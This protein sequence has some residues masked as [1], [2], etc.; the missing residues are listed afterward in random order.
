MELRNVEWSRMVKNDFEAGWMDVMKIKYWEKM[1]T[2]LLIN[3]L[4]CSAECCKSS[5]SLGCE[6]SV[7]SGRFSSARWESPP[8]TLPSF[9]SHEHKLLHKLQARFF[10]PSLLNSVSVSLL[11]TGRSKKERK[12]KEK[13]TKENWNNQKKK[14]TCTEQLGW[15]SAHHMLFQSYF[16]AHHR[17]AALFKQRAQ[18]TVLT[19]SRFLL[20]A[21]V[22][23]LIMT[24]R[25]N[26]IRCNTENIGLTFTL[27]AHSSVAVPFWMN[28]CVKVWSEHH[29]IFS[30][31]LFL[32]SFHFL[33][34]LWNLPRQLSEHYHHPV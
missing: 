5:L 24:W 34:H 9:S 2:A 26:P 22:F 23:C 14:K 19:P 33:F 12:K 1:H 28:Q 11:K 6:L 29:F 7:F 30:L 31:F 15:I 27:L 4:L 20:V 13:K 32:F 16:L 10:I 25:V 17:T 18:S 3:Q 21:A 8:W